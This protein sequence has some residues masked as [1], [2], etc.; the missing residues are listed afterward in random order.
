V[1]T[2][3]TFAQHLAEH[4]KL[5]E[6]AIVM[7]RSPDSGFVQFNV[8]I[9]SKEHTNLQTEADTWV[10]Y[11]TA[12]GLASMVSDNSMPAFLRGAKIMEAQSAL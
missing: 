1:Q 3:D 4:L 8:L 7:R 6:V 10:V 11:A 2:T 12:V 5:E 9:S